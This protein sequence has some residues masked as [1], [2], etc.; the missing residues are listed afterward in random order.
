MRIAVTGHRPDKLGG[1]YNVKGPYTQHIHTQLKDAIATLKPTLMISGLA[2]GVD[3]IWALL[4]MELSIPLMAVIPFPSQDNKWGRESQK[5]YAILKEYARKTGG[6]K[7]TGT[8]PYEYW[9]MDIRNQYM[10]NNCDL[11]IAVYNGDKKGGTFNCL[12]YAESVEKPILKI[13]PTPKDYENQGVSDS[14]DPFE[15]SGL[16]SIIRQEQEGRYGSI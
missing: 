2:L 10:V 5:L 12:T 8:D 6:L 7:V 1:E 15:E 16:W 9:K 4:A 11:L 14:R 13:N 3:T